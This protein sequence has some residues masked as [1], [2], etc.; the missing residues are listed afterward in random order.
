M[1]TKI[2]FQAR[3]DS[4]KLK[5]ISVKHLFT[6]WK[7]LFGLSFVCIC[8]LLKLLKQEDVTIVSGRN[9][10]ATVP[11]THSFVE[12]NRHKLLICN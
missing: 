8:K 9:Y 5:I 11:Q 12:A 7:N 2:P 3:K 10:K 4:R 6:L 1:V